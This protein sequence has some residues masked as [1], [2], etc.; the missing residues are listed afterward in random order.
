ML[1]YA[2]KSLKKDTYKDLAS[3]DFENIEDFL[4]AILVKG[5]SME[6]KKGLAK[7]YIFLN[8]ETSSIKG[9]IDL[10]SSIKAQSFYKSKMYCS[11]DEFTTNILLNQILKSTMELLLRTNI[12]K[13]R[14][15][16][17]RRLLIYFKDVDL[18]DL[19]NI[20]WNFRFS[21]NNQ[22][23]LML[24]GICKLIIE[25]KIQSQR[26]GDDRLMGFFDEQKTYY[27]F[28]NFILEYYK[29]HFPDINTAA[30]EIKWQ[31]DDENN[32]L[33]PRMF[34]DIY[35]EYDR[36]ILIIDA[37]YYKNNTQKNY[38][39]ATIWS[40]NLYQIYT[41]VKNTEYRE[42]LNIDD[43]EEKK[44][45]SAMLLYAKTDGQ[46]QPNQIYQMAGNQIE[47]KS[48]DLNQKFP[49]IRQDLD[50]I[51]YDYFDLGS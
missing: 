31:L 28:Q 48:L 7:D 20:N 43:Q 46:I 29:E 19:R 44:K 21:R 18:I 36:N 47:V 6:I 15:K 13:T 35:L 3:E 26:D 30:R 27:L 9:K 40:N 12:P 39:R 1:A 50:Q 10:A 38:G 42:N 25:S 2:Y 24:I 41:Y 22:N 45:I 11:F 33:L 49:K 23:Y 32:N 4:S 34:S 37:K 17:I 51:V 16:D 14:Q 8:E 5:V